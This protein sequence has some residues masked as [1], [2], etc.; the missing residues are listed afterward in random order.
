MM[1][2]DEMKAVE[3]CK[4]KFEFIKPNGK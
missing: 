2:E 1:D 3:Y 4:D